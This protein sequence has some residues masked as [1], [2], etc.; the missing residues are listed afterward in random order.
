MPGTFTVL[1]VML[2]LLAP[3]SSTGRSRL[4]VP[5]VIVFANRESGARV[6]LRSVDDN[7]R[8]MSALER[9]SGAADTVGRPAFDVAMFFA[10]SNAATVGPVDKIPLSL[11]DLRAVYF[12]ADGSRPALLLPRGAVSG[13]ALASSTVSETGL[14]VLAR[15]GIR[16]HAG[17]R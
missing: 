17:A 16:T 9:L 5:A 3:I 13:G 4:A 1:A 7:R 6:V 10:F 8:F 2:A 11:A 12:P 14:R 15:H